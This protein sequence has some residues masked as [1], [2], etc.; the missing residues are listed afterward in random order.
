M[1]CGYQGRDVPQH[2]A[3]RG[4]HHA[5]VV[6]ANPRKRGRFVPGSG[7]EVVTPDDLRAAPPGAVVVTNPLYRDENRGVVGRAGID[8]PVAAA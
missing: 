5:Q 8:V 6:D 1:G 4:P 7:Q 2:R 3:G